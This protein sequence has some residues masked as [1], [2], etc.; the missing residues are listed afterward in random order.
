MTLKDFKFESHCISN[1]PNQTPQSWVYLVKPPDDSIG[2]LDEN[3]PRDR[4]F[5]TECIA[6]GFELVKSSVYD[7]FLRSRRIRMSRK[8]DAAGFKEYVQHRYD[9][10]RARVAMGELTTDDFTWGEWEEYMLGSIGY[11]IK[12]DDT[13]WE[14]LVQPALAGQ[15]RPHI[16][17]RHMI[18]SQ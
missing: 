5:I 16:D 12:M 9:V 17:A 3:S 4:A 6:H 14:R 18:E 1:P 15:S 11:H 2:G 7:E 8:L 13:R 10:Q